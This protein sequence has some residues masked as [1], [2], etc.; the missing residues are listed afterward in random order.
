MGRVTAGAMAVPELEMALCD[1]LELNRDA[2]GVGGDSLRPPSGGGDGRQSKADR[3]LLARCAM[4]FFREYV[5]AAGSGSDAAGSGSDARISGA[6]GE[7]DFPPGSES[8]CLASVASGQPVG[9]RAN[10]VWRV[11]GRVALE[12]AKA[13][14][15]PLPPLL[16]PPLAAL[17]SRLLTFARD[18]ADYDLMRD[19]RVVLQQATLAP[20][21]LGR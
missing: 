6:L 18:T 17:P 5:A 10:A 11:G 16:L 12:E 3:L 13:T 1:A 21:G 19:L 7:T 4:A 2:D 15:S 20:V 9:H 14:S 8:G